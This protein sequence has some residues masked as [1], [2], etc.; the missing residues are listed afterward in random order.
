M[1][2]KAFVNKR[3]IYV[4]MAYLLFLYNSLIYLAISYEITLLF[5]Y[6]CIL[7]VVYYT[8]VARH[9]E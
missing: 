2:F 6:L 4:P 8:G 7:G 9:Q 3:L 1:K 5:D